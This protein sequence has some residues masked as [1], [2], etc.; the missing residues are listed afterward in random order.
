MKDLY[1]AT[2]NPNKL[3]EA[4]K[5][6]G[7]KL[8]QAKIDV[9]EIQSLEASEV[10]EG[11]VKHAYTVLDKPVITEDTALHVKEWNGFPGA[12]ITWIVKTIGIEKLCKMIGKERGATAKACVSY[13]NGNT[14]KTFCGEINGR[15]SKKPRGA[16]RFDWDR[17]FTP[18]GE[19]RTFA[20]MPLEEKNR[21][22][23][24]MKA[25]GK[26][27]EFLESEVK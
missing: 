22:S 6:L 5:I 4:E 1:F 23:H 27:R 2:T 14:L 13:F 20:E 3:K 10:A 19:K 21:I 12:L 16:D 15:I 11:K 25:F 17:I 24:R 8:K 7:I 26:L 18:E 9:P